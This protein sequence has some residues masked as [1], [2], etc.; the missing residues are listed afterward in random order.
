M[1]MKNKILPL[2]ILL[3][4]TALMFSCGKLKSKKGGD[5]K[6]AITLKTQR[7]SD[8]SSFNMSNG[9]RCTI[10]A[11][12]T[13]D[14]PVGTADGVAADSLQRLFASYVLESGDTL[15]LQEAM[16][17][18]VA[19]SMHQ[20]DFMTEPL[21]D[22]EAAE[23]A[24][25]DDMNTLKY[26]TSTRIT[27]IYN[28]NGVVTFE[29]VDV[30]KK[31]DKVTS[32]THRYYSFDA[33]TQTYIDLPNLFRDDAIADVC[34]LLKQQLLKQNNAKGNEQLNDLGFFNVENISVTRNFYFDDKGMTWSYLPNEL[35]VEAVGE[36]KITIPY[37][38]LDGA[39]CEESIIERLK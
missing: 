25:G 2:F 31:N 9:E 1:K 13:I 3:S 6:P 37:G 33:L 7:L 23:A 35:A 4:I 26:A 5:G 8:K 34:Q 10:V 19:N 39:L 16:R 12:A 28:K 27:P 30:V 36:P 20:Y 15:S 29:R 32:V 22:E 24:E 18:V 21:S 14:Y 11:D 17:Q 38:D